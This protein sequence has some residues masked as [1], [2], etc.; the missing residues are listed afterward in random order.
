MTHT[1]HTPNLTRRELLFTLWVFVMFLYAY[2]DILG[3]Y[4][5]EILK[6]L[7]SGSIDGIV[8]DQ[9]MLLAAS[10]LM[11]LPITTILITR[12]ASYPIARWTNIGVGSF[13]TLV[14]LATLLTPCTI[15][16]WLFAVIEISTTIAIVWLAWGWQ[17]QTNS[18]ANT[19][20]PV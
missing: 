6:K 11:I 1:D 13:K 4:D 7:L 16:Y 2:C 14:M 5:V 8:M 12:I 19:G 17:K 15:Y 3:L 20:V 9:N 18:L 10:V